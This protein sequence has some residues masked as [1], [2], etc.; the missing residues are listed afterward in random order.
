MNKLFHWIISLLNIKSCWHRWE[1]KTLAWIESDKILVRSKCK[2]CGLVK[3]D[4]L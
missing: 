1:V 3:E 4:I 2:H